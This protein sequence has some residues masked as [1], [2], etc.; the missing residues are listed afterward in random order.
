MYL[1]SH[2]GVNQTDMYTLPTKQSIRRHVAQSRVT[3]RKRIRHGVEMIYLS[4]ADELNLRNPPS[5]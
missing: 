4:Q 3:G 1:D 5:G 2:E